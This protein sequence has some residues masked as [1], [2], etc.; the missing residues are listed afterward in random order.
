M[1][2][3]FRR[4]AYGGIL[5]YR[6]STIIWSAFFKAAKISLDSVVAKCEKKLLDIH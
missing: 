2:L 1:W 6:Y 5:P 4:P 3:S